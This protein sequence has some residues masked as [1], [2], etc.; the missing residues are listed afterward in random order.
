MGWVVIDTPR[1]LLPPEKTRYP[2]YRRLGGLQGRSGHVR[3]ILPPTGFDPRTIQPVA[4]HYTD[5]AIPAPFIIWY[6]L[7]MF[8]LICWFNLHID[9][10]LILYS[11]LRI[12]LS[13]SPRPLSTPKF[14]V[15]FSFLALYA[16]SLCC[17]TFRH[18]AS[19]IQDRRFATPRRTLFIYLINKYISLSD[20]CLTVHHWYK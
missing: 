14:C 10:I 19:S 12:C 9:S 20:I 8:I 5:W 1:P 16:M 3:K 7:Y 13:S 17:L 2:L 15:H 18:R 6:I 11:L 4:G